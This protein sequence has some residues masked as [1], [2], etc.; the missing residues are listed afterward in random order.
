MERFTI[1][2]DSSAKFQ[3]IRQALAMM[4]ALQGLPA[5]YQHQV[6]LLTTDYLPAYLENQYRSRSAFLAC[7][8]PSLLTHDLQQLQQRG[9]VTMAVNNAAKIVR[10]QLW[11]CADPPYRFARTIWEDPTITKFL[12]IEQITETV[13]LSPSNTSEFASG[14]TVSQMPNV[15]G[16]IRNLNFSRETW[17]Q[18]PSVNYGLNEGDSDPLG[19]EGVRSVLLVALKLLYHLGFR[20]V[21][22]IGCDFRMAAG[23]SNYA[24]NQET[25]QKYIEKNCRSYEVLNDRLQYLRP[26]FEEH[27]Y[28]VFNCTPE[29]GLTAFPFMEY[30]QAVSESLTS[31]QMSESG[32]YSVHRES[33]PYALPELI[34]SRAA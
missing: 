8:G 32:T 25:D 10:P 14:P 29:S 13:E 5:Q 17:L 16:Y 11:C 27:N 19:H 30:E 23:R 28:Q 4:D 26:T 24:F 34:P 15:F 2:L 18:E 3:V 7:S 6:P 9:I 12:P 20:R 21:Y 31:P 33:D 22:L 1:T